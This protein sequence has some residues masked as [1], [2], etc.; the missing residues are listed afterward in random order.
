LSR[1]D[2]FGRLGDPPSALEVGQPAAGMGDRTAETANLSGKGGARFADGIA[3][4]F[5]DRNRLR[6]LGG[7]IFAPAGKRRHR[8]LLQVGDAAERGFQP[9][10][11]RLVLS[12]GERQR[13]LAAIDRRRRVP[14]LLFQDQQGA[15]VRQLFFG[16]GDRAAKKR[17]KRLE[18]CG[19]LVYERCSRSLYYRFEHCSRLMNIVHEKVIRTMKTA[20]RRQNLKESLISVAERTI[21]GHGLGGVRARAL[22]DKAGCAVG[23]IYNVVADLDELILLVN[24]RTFAALE[25]AF[26]AAGEDKET[27]TP[28]QA[29]ERLVRLSMVYTDFAAT[30]TQRWRALFE[31]RLSQ[32]RRIPDWYLEEQMRLFSY[33][34]GPLRVLHPNA[35]PERLGLLARSLVS[36]VHGIVTLGLE[37]K[38]YTLP[39]ASLREQVTFVVSAIGRGLASDQPPS[40]SRAAANR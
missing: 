37:E 38:L 29:I 26:T 12:D 17:D 33:V 22:A 7:Q 5:Q 40:P 9:L 18:H 23:A 14:D 25:R 36:A 2:G 20:E 10:S 19:L 11:F 1:P 24:S 8:A 31:H 3:I 35:S 28:D 21:E 16:G 4:R 32:G 15:A 13:P 34:E 6:R 27:R 39:L 30:N